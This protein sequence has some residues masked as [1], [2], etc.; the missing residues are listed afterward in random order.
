MNDVLDGALLTTYNAAYQKVISDALNTVA[1]WPVSSGDRIV[2][3]A[4]GSADLPA[5]LAR[6]V[7]HCTVIHVDPNAAT[8]EAIS[9]QSEAAGLTN[10]HVL[11]C[12]VRDAQFFPRS[13]AGITMIHS[14]GEVEQPTDFVRT[15]AGWLRPGGRVFAC[16]AGRVMNPWQSMAYAFLD[17]WGQA[18]ASGALMLALSARRVVKRQMRVR[19]AQQRGQYWTHTP[20]EFRAAF[21]SAPLAVERT[22]TA[23]HGCSDVLVAVKSNAAEPAGHR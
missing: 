1:A 7:P 17:T 8:C 20:H 9:R 10:L 4:G 13:V 21:E 11:C 2:N 5:R 16:D 23:F 18:G 15:I 6:R 22:Y 3:F 12:D 14:L 19:S